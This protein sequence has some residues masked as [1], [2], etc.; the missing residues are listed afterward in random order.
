MVRPG[1]AH[2]SK[3]SQKRPFF[4]SG[5]VKPL[6][7]RAATAFGSPDETSAT[8][9]AGASHPQHGAQEEQEQLPQQKHRHTPQQKHRHKS[10]VDERKKLKKEDLAVGINAWITMPCKGSNFMIMM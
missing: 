1:V 8:A 2:E 5:V 7:A 3:Q 10:H 6:S 4:H 9:P